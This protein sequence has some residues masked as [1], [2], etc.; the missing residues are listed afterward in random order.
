MLRGKSFVTYL[1]VVSLI[2]A[3]VPVFAQQ[4]V[5][6]VTITVAEPSEDKYTQEPK[7]VIVR[8]GKVEFT[9]VNKGTKDHALAAKIQ[10]KDIRLV[11]VATPGQSAK[12]EPVELSAGEYEIYCNRTTGGSHKNKGMVGKL[13]VK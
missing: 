3:A 6:K 1:F 12:G 13:I 4:E 11:R 7:E 2:F 5:Q 10:D 9:L 8:P